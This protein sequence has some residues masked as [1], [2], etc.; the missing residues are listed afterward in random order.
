M[1]GPTSAPSRP[2]SFLFVVWDGGGNVPPVLSLGRGLADRGHR[3]RVLA[4]PSLEGR[5]RAAGLEPRPFVV[6]RGNDPTGG[7][8]FE[9]QPPLF[10]AELFFG[11]PVAQDVAN[12]LER[13]RPDVVVVDFMLVASLAAAEASGV[14]TVALVHTLFSFLEGYEGM[15]DPAL[16]VLNPTRSELGLA[17]LDPDEGPLVTQLFD[18][19]SLVVVTTARAFDRPSYAAGEN[20][21]FVGLQPDPPTADDAAALDLTS[22]DPLVLVSLSTTY[23]HQEAVLG[24]ILTGLGSL[25]VQAVVTLGLELGADELPAA[26]PNCIVRRWV[27]HATLLP[28]ASVVVTHAGHGT[29]IAAVTNGVPLVCIP[30]GRDQELNARRVAEA[31]CGLVLPATASP[32][33]ITDAVREVLTDPRYRD[34]AGLMAAAIRDELAGTDPV[35]ELER[36][37]D[38]RAP[39]AD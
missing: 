27:P 11:A 7:R 38:Q 39:A 15:V 23:Q 16:V 37:L 2:G 22:G 3:V 30:M 28:D 32:D 4:P 8:A 12:E 17:P 35:G 24:A 34:A 1:S 25:P 33:E 21:R 20:V 10:L 18:R 14:P 6:G 13:D 26:P 19:C 5:I 29:V 9:D 36:L 31:G